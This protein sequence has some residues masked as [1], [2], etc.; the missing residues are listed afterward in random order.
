MFSCIHFCSSSRN[1]EIDDLV[2][3]KREEG[4]LPAGPGLIP[5]LEGVFSPPQ[6]TFA[7]EKKQSLGSKCRCFFHCLTHFLCLLHVSGSLS[8]GVCALRSCESPPCPYH[9]PG[10]QSLPVF[11]LLDTLTPLI[12]PPSS[13]SLL[14]QR[15][16]LHTRLL[17]PRT[18]PA[19]LLCLLYVLRLLLAHTFC[20]SPDVPK[21]LLMPHARRCH[22]QLS[23]TPCIWTTPKAQIP[24]LNFSLI[25]RPAYLAAGWAPLW[26]SLVSGWSKAASCMDFPL[27]LPYLLVLLDHSFSQ[28]TLTQPLLCVRHGAR[29]QGDNCE[30][31][32][33]VLP[34]FS[35]I[36]R[37][38]RSPG[39]HPQVPSVLHTPTPRQSH[40]LVAK[41][42]SIDLLSVSGIFLL[43]FISIAPV[44]VQA[45][46][47]FWDNFRGLLTCSSSLCSFPPPSCSPCS[48]SFQKTKI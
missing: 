41:A 35:T 33:K 15:L 26:G 14:P 36:V 19:Y 48:S 43:L 30:E 2:N 8:S 46:P 47:L 9:W 31:E 5:A 25:F 11:V 23:V 3:G 21:S 44:Q 16:R 18:S 28:Q 10:Q 1:R 24:A 7:F 22:P 29:C 6:N 20:C 37:D 34:L 12:P 32:N 39:H 4:P 27:L 42:G 45:F 38:I 13:V 17:S 40:Q